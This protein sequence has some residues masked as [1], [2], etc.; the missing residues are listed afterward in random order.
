M[1]VGLGFIGVGNHGRH[2][3]KV[4]SRLPNCRL[5]CVFDVDADRAQSVVSDFPSLWCA[6]SLEALL[7]DS[8]VNGV[9][10]ATP[11]E[12]HR[13]LVES[14]LAAGRSVLL[15]KPMAHTPEDALAITQAA[16]AHPECVFMVGHCER[17]NRAYVDVRKAVEDGRV[18]VPRFI[19]ASRL[20]PLHLNDPGWKLGVLDTAVHD[21]DVILWLMGDRPVSVA[22]QGTSANP[23]LAIHDQVSYQIEFEGRGLAQGH[24][25]W[26]PFGE[27]YPM[28][29]N[30]HPRLFLAGTGGTISLDLWQRPVAVH[31]FEEGTYFWADDVLV[32]YGDYFTE[33]TAQNYAF[34]FAVAESRPLPMR[35]REAY[36]A[37]QVAY[38]AYESLHRRDGGPVTLNVTE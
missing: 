21:I 20:S 4:F 6:P 16:E 25:G 36:E 17:F 26:I 8:E 3:L 10:I 35:P 11:A 28:R 2:H 19:W 27:S 23:D 22:A 38:A 14:V 12:T 7:S 37:V 34:V 18:G 33:I 31:S 30:A 29:R 1:E 15:E 13:S 24:I 32:G 5:V 9:V